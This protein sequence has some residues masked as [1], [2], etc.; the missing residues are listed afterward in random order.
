MNRKFFKQMSVESQELP[1]MVI[2]E[3]S[4]FYQAVVTL[5]HRQGMGRA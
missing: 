5:L 3:N 1:A 4:D 2:R